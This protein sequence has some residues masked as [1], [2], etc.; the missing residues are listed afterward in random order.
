MSNTHCNPLISSIIYLVSLSVN[1]TSR[2]SRIYDHTDPH[3]HSN[4]MNW[5]EV[6]GYYHE[7]QLWLLRCLILLCVFWN[8]YVVMYRALHHENLSIMDPAP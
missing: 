8:L 3:G 5:G 1:L 6:P 7:A 4:T 2:S